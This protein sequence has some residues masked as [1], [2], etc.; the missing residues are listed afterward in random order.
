ME[1]S[2][3]SPHLLEVVFDL[4]HS[5]I[6][7]EKKVWDKW[8]FFMDQM[9]FL[10]PNEQQKRTLK[11]ETLLEENILAFSYLYSPQESCK[12]ETWSLLLGALMLA[13]R[14]E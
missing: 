14:Y 4:Q 3:R 12:K 13:S 5:T 1:A 6:S 10:T 11:T 8:Q 7:N 2:D 9:P